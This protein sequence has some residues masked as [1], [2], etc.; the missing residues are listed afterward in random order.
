MTGQVPSKV[1]FSRG[2]GVHREKLAS[3]ELALRDARIAWYNLVEVSSIMPPE[4][5]IIPQEDG[6]ALLKAGQIVHTVLSQNSSNEEG[7]LVSAAIGCAIPQDRTRHGYI[8]EHHEFGMPEEKIGE[9]AEDM[10]AEMLASTLGIEYDIDA[11]Y[12]E[13]RDI[14]RIDGRIVN[15][16]HIAVAAKSESNERWTTVVAAAVLIIE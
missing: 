3:F 8:S 15:T 1:F 11:G 4:C 7:R 2:I 9:Y 14:F 12:D 13:V 16:Q 6:I 10:A 5:E